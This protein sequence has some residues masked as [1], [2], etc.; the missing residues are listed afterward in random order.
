VMN[1]LWHSTAF[2]KYKNPMSE[3]FLFKWVQLDQSASALSCA[4]FICF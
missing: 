2:K 1:R 3:S 4:D